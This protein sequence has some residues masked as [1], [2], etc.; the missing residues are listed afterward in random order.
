MSEHLP[1]KYVKIFQQ[2]YPEVNKIIDGRKKKVKVIRPFN[3]NGDIYISVFT[4]D[5]SKWNNKDYKT[6]VYEEDSV[7]ITPFVSGNNYYNKQFLKKMTNKN[8]ILF[9][10]GGWN[11]PHFKGRLYNV[12][13]LGE[14][15]EPTGNYFKFKINEKI[16]DYI[17]NP[18]DPY[19]RRGY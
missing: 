8:L 11:K 2:H 14:A 12:K 17:Y 16:Q 6:V 4:L 10:G 7:I 13:L 1:D 9:V 19:N 15:E 5:Y 3:L 18:N